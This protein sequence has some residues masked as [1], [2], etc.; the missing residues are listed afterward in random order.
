[1]YQNVLVT[2]NSLAVHN[3]NYFVQPM[4]QKQNDGAVVRTAI[5]AKAS[6]T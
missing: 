2:I 3:L 1:M 6:K 5:T 4:L